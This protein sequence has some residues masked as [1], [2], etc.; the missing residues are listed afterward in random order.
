M[1]RGTAYRREIRVHSP[2]N[3]ATR[4][5]LAV[6]PFSYPSYP[7]RLTRSNSPNFTVGHSLSMTENTTVSR[8]VLVIVPVRPK[9]DSDAGST[10][11][12]GLRG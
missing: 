8:T 11:Q 6:G 3:W 2:Q 1:L 7:A 5:A 9:L 10:T 12:I 4:P